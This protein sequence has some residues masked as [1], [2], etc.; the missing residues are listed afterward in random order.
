MEF[1]G[2]LGS[3][4]PKNGDSG[5]GKR[6]EPGSGVDAEIGFIVS[7]S[8]GLDCAAGKDDSS[9]AREEETW[10]NPAVSLNVHENTAG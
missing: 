9:Q 6:G 1:I 7:L 5:S 3:E 2:L 10:E 4:T 8:N